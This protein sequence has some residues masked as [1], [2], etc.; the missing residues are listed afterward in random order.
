MSDFRPSVEAAKKA[1]GD[2]IFI[3]TKDHPAGPKGIAFS[4]D[5]VAARVRKGRNDPRVRA[6]AI[7][8]INKAGVGGPNRTREQAEA[9]LSALHEAVVYVSDPLNTEFIQ[10]AHETLCLDDKGLC[11]KGGD[12]FAKGT[13]V[14]RKTRII[15][16]EH[17]FLTTEDVIGI[18]D[19]K[20]GDTI[21]GFNGWTHVEAWVAKGPLAVDSISLSDG[22][23]LH[24]TH[25]HHVF[26]TTRGPHSVDPLSDHGSRF[27][28]GSTDVG[29]T[30]AR[31]AAPRIRVRDLRVGDFLLQPSSDTQQALHGYATPSAIYVK[32]VE[33]KSAIVE[34]FDIQTT[35]HYVYLPEHRVVVS[36]C[37]DLVVAYGSACLSVGIPVQVI[38]QSF[39]EGQPPSHVMCAIQC[40]REDRWLKVDPSTDK[41]VGEYVFAVKEWTID[42]MNA[43]DKA[44]QSIAGMGDF[45]GVGRLGDVPADALTQN[46]VVKQV[47]AALYDLQTSV[48]GLETAL[49]QVASITKV[50]GFDPE[51]AVSITSIASFPTSGIWT[52]TMDKIARD[53]LSQGAFQVSAGQDALA[54]ARAIYLDASNAISI[55]K[56]PTDSVTW[57]VLT[58]GTEAILAIT[59]PAGVLLGGITAAVGEFLQPP[60]IQADET[61]GTVQGLGI[62]PAVIVA[63]AV[64]GTLVAIAQVVAVYAIT[65]KLCSMITAVAHEKSRQSL[66]A[67]YRECVASGKC[68]A[69]DADAAL[70]ASQQL[71][72][73]AAKTDAENNPFGS[74]LDSFAT[75]LKWVAIGGLVVVGTMV[76]Y[77][78]VKEIGM[79]AADALKS[80]RL[81]RAEA[82]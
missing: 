1:L 61:S 2:R 48:T 3:E 68:T 29:F 11:F 51:P 79:S 69:K 58:I 31:F 41:P 50:T 77:P 49:A 52:A 72:N 43:G 54:G 82:T 22:P 30:D 19:V 33:R 76:A 74:T 14:L 12:C 42:P 37:D 56:L 62:G 78:V 80:K 47:Q 60:Q 66:I 10:A 65:S 25:D 4:L 34:C 70:L 75:I 9:I 18:E 64:A 38:G 81:A 73:E 67:Y 39:R 53:F 23:M 24:L 20:A 40:T 36:Q 28:K 8:A 44:T 17:G 5:E 57:S 35:D 6:W 16:D 63:I 13:K 7:R 26:V 32:G 21:W 27:D 15:D 46:V 45:V 55:G 71:D 59:N